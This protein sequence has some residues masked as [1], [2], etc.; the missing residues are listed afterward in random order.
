MEPASIDIGLS[1]YQLQLGK[2]NFT[3]VSTS[4]LVILRAKVRLIL[5]L[6]F[7]AQLEFENLTYRSVSL[8][9]GLSAK[10]SLET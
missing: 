6:N 1:E 4:M 9:F 2:L 3:D 8:I 5:R 7:Q 10:L